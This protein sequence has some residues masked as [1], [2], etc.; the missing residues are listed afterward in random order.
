[1]KLQH[2][3]RGVSKVTFF[4]NEFKILFVASLANAYNRLEFLCLATG[5]CEPAGGSGHVK[6]LNRQQ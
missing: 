2:S 4:S 6:S 3:P 5:R 1:M